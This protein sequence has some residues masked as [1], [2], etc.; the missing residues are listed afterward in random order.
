M[1][2]INA[3]VLIDRILITPCYIYNHFVSQINSQNV[4]KESLGAKLV[5]LVRWM[6]LN[7]EVPG[8]NLA[9]PSEKNLLVLLDKA[10]YLMLSWIMT[11]FCPSFMS[12]ACL[13]I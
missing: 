1:V 13:R 8:S 11:T 12:I 2:F 10:L 6:T 9:R 4:T 5:Q 3:Y 7:Q